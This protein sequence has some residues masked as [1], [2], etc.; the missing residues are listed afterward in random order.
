MLTTLSNL[1]LTWRRWRNMATRPYRRKLAARRFWRSQSA[2]GS[3]FYDSFPALAL[4]LP[5]TLVA[6]GV[7]S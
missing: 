4:I 5:F 2:T 1:C 6:S 7:W 3:L